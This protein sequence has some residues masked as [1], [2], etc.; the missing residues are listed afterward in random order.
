[1]TNSSL[2]SN[3][4][5]T[6]FR[7]RKEFGEQPVFRVRINGQLEE[8]IETPSAA[9]VRPLVTEP[10]EILVQYK[11]P[12]RDVVV[13]PLRLGI[14]PEIEGNTLRFFLNEP[15]GVSVEI[16]GDLDFPLLVLAE[17]EIFPPELAPNTI[18]LGKG[19]HDASEITLADD[20]VL[21][22]DHGARLSGP[23]HLRGLKNV[24]IFGLGIIDATNADPA[25]NK[26]A[27]LL[28]RCENVTISGPLGFMCGQWGCIIRSSRQIE[29]RNLK[30]LGHEKCSDGIDVDGS[31]H[32][33][34]S[35]CF[36]K[37]N[38]D[39]LCIKSS[40]LAEGASVEDVEFSNCTLWNGPAGNGI[41]LGYESQTHAFR[42]IT[43]RNIDII[44]VQT[45]E[46][47][48]WVDRMAAISMHITHDAHVQNVLFENITIEDVQTP[49][50]IQLTTFHYYRDHGWFSPADRLAKGKI[51]NVRLKNVHFLKAFECRVHVEGFN[52]PDDI[53]NVSFENVT[54]EGVNLGNR[55]D[56]ALEVV[57]TKNF[58]IT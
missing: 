43:F 5:E 37:N 1:M 26:T 23:L 15:C 19:N 52:G 41:E 34:V 35:G 29:V 50:M 58:S 8:I 7:A 6:F 47:G 21:F 54:L 51:S 28:D 48:G 55:P 20:S 57:N 56:L 53:E 40:P 25:K 14:V 13:R 49:K 18:I 11:A 33:R 12:V 42:D 38:D 36:I 39:C 2:V 46:G 44:H 10:L 27:I 3:G 31:H 4:A 32:V 45:E 30:L 9:V 24:R 17:E 16:N 22:L